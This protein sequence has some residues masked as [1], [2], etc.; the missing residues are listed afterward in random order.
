MVKLWIKYIDFQPNPLNLYKILYQQGIGT[1]CA[2]FY[3]GW[4]HYYNSSNLFKQAESI[5]NLGIQLKAQPIEE[6]VA[7]Q[8]N[9][10]FSLAQRMLYN[11]ESSKKRTI[12]NLAEQRQ[13]VTS[14]KSPHQQA[15]RL[16]MDTPSTTQEEPFNVNEAQF[17]SHQYASTSFDPSQVISSSLS[18]LPYVYGDGSYAQIEEQEIVQVTGTFETGFQAPKSF[19]DCAKNSSELWDVPLF[20]EEL[21]DPNS[22]C[23][24]PKR[25]CYPGSGIEFSLEELKAKKWLLQMEQKR[26]EESLR[27]HQEEERLRQESEAKRLIV[28]QSRIRDEQEALRMQL[29]R[30]KLHQTGH[31]AEQRNHHPPYQ[32][33]YQQNSNWNC[34]EQSPA[35]Y[36]SGY[37]Q[38]SPYENSPTYSYTHDHRYQS[39]FNYSYPNLTSFHQQSTALNNG[40]HQ[41]EAHQMQPQPESFFSSAV[42]QPQYSEYMTYQ[43]LPQVPV[44][45][46]RSHEQVNQILPTIPEKCDESSNYQDVEFLIDGE[47]D[48]N[49]L[50]QPIVESFENGEES[51]NDESDEGVMTPVVN[52]YMLDD[53]EEQIE[54]STISFSS[55]GKSRDKKITIKFRKEK[56]QASVANY[57]ESNSESSLPHSKNFA[58]RNTSSNKSSLEPDPTSSSSIGKRKSKKQKFQSEMR[59]TFDGD[60]TQFMQSTTNSCSS[61]ANGEYN[62]EFANVSFNDFNGCVTP[63]KKNISKTSTPSSSSNLLRKTGSISSQNEDSICSFSGDQNSFFQAEDDEDLKKRRY[64]RALL[65]ID[66]HL[67]RREIDPF[68]SEL[69]RA[70]LIKLNFPNRENTTDYLLTNYNLPKIS[71][72][73]VVPINGISYQIEKEV[74]RGTYGSVWRGINTTDGSVV[75]LKYQKTPN[76]WELYICSEIRRRLTNKDIVSLL[77]HS[78]SINFLRLFFTV[79]RFYVNYWGSHCSQCQCFYIRV[80]PIWFSF[81]CE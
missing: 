77:N 2:A 44:V 21:F 48:P 38:H 36:A 53:L 72:N 18:H 73:Q 49:M 46:T 26:K 13:Q 40:N 27:Q 12:S 76:S 57:L 69:C 54:A 30:E 32:I 41:Y 50:Q 59:N 28:E 11:D 78:L 16:K 55:N 25:S 3:I 31:P 29:E 19:V 5:F 51:S 22:R 35:T 74:G 15:K 6:L 66:E 80:L 9:F 79:T 7:A 67:S 52:S 63:A 61:I 20:L 70:L 33:A 17:D 68:N 60:N 81:G 58:E 62:S 47:I 75:A 42:H 43:P 23:F 34:Y 71:K 65:T 1:S 39:P 64:E 14:L 8:K 24:Y 45:E 37:Y 4:A 56:S 10:R